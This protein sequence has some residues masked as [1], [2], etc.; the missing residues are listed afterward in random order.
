MT[1]ERTGSRSAAPRPDPAAKPKLVL[2][3]EAQRERFRERSRGVR[4]LPVAV[5][6][7]V[8]LAG[9]AMLALPGPAFVV[10]PIGLAILSL[11]FTWAERLLDRS[12]EEAAKA[13][14]KAAQTSTTQRVL[15]GVACALAAA[16]FVVWAVLGDVPLLPV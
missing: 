1:T 8:V 5:G 11:Q 10:I 15:T 2:R 3:L 4:Y 6:A 7:A 12:L 14:A 16:A 9:L 13:Q